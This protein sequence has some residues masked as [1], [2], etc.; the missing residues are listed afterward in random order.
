[1]GLTMLSG[2]R[3]R[4]VDRVKSAPEVASTLP[5]PHFELFEPADFPAA[6]V[7][8]GSFDFLSLFLFLDPHH[9]GSY[10]VT[11]HTWP[12]ACQ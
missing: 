10:P 11:H 12:T 8:G 4:G 5:L 6:R 2:L 9:T 3:V 7:V 1:M